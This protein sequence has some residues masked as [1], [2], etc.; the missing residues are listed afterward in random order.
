MLDKLK[1]IQY[2]LLCVSSRY[3]TN[4][5]TLI[6]STCTLSPDENEAVAEKFLLEHPDFTPLPILPDVQRHTHAADHIIT[7]F[8]HL[9]R[10]DGFFIAAFRRKT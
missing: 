7:I 5:G 9:H 4:G 8:P 6:Y 2:P 10:C 1:Q 3:V